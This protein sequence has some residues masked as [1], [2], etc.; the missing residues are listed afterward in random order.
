MTRVWVYGAG[1][2]GCLAGG[3]LAAAGCPVVLI[4]RREVLAPVAEKGLR[5]RVPAGALPSRPLVAASVEEAGA[6][7]PPDLVLVTVKAWATPA[8]A[9]DLA[10]TLPG[11]A[12]AVLT[13]QNGL[14]NEETLAAALGPERVWSGALTA[15]VRWDGPG[16]VAAAARGGLALTSL[17]RPGAPGPGSEAAWADLTAAFRRGGF[18]VVA[19]AAGHPSVK[20]SKL[21]LNLLGNAVPAAL[22]QPPAVCLRHPLAFRLEREAFAEACRVAAAEGAR[23]HDLPGYPVRLLRLL[24][25]GLPAPLAHRLLYRPLAGGRGDKLPSFLLD[26]RAGRRTEAAFLYGAVAE[27]GRARGVPAP[28]NAALAALLDDLAAGRADRDRFRGRPDR[29]WEYV[30]ERARHS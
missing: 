6:A 29:L 11:A 5:V 21:L 18:P 15:A 16:E 12:C 10:R 25:L 4:G 14:G 23:V 19:D 27:R 13:L 8:A 3:L 28:V 22:D 2:V 9:A 7:F 30:R 20:W 1:A 26:L 24:L 17:V